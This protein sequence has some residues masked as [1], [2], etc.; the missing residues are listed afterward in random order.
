MTKI[1]LCAVP[2]EVTDIDGQV[3][4][5]NVSGFGP[6]SFT[7]EWTGCGWYLV[8]TNDWSGS[9]FLPHIVAAYEWVTANYHIAWNDGVGKVSQK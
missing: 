6:S 9:I 2:Y 7:F 8:D 1:S 4:F 3:I 5:K